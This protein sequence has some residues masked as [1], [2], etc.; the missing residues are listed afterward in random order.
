MQSMPN[1]MT[2]Q[3]GQYGT[4]HITQWSIL[5]A[6]CKAPK[7]RH[8]VKARAVLARLTLWSLLSSSSKNTKHN[9]F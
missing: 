9:Y 5:V 7:R 1:A 3:L 8:W 6:S 4:R 2:I